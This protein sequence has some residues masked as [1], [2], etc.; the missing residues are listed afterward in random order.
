SMVTAVTIE[1]NALSGLNIFTP[2]SAGESGDVVIRSFNDNL[3]IEDLLI[4]TT[5]RAVDV[6]FILRGEMLSFGDSD[7]SQ[8]GNVRIDSAGNVVFDNVTVQSSSNGE[9]PAGNVF[10]RSP[11]QIAF[12]NSDIISNT[13]STGGAGNIQIES[14]RLVLGEGDLISATTSGAG[15]GGNISINATEAVLLGEGVQ[16]SAPVIS[17]E[18]SGAGRPGNIV[19]NTPNFTLSETAR[20][21]ATSTATAT[22]PNGGGSIDLNANQMALAGTVGIFAETQGQA[23]GGLLTLRPYQADLNSSTTGQPQIP[24]IESDTILSTGASFSLTLAE[25]SLISASTTSS[26]NG[27]GLRLLA[28]E[29]I[30]ISGPGHLAVE[31]SGTGQAGNVTANARFLT[32]SNGVVLSAST[33]GIG[34]AGNINF[35]ISERLTIDNSTVESRTASNSTGQGGN[36][37]VSSS[38]DILLL[39]GGNF[40]LNS[41][42]TGE[43][44]DFTL[45]AD[46]LALD[47]GEIT[48]ITQSSNGGDFTFN[49]D[50]Y[51]LL[52]NGSLIST[53]AG[54][55][56]EGGNGGSIA[57]NAPNGFIIAKPEENSDIR[58]NAF[59][60]DG[61]NVNITALNLLGIAFRPGLSDTPASD[62]TSSSQFGNSGTVTIDELNPETLQPDTE[63][64][65]ETAPATVA[66]G[67]RAQG[68]QTG[69]FVSTGRGGLPASPVSPLSNSPIWQD[70]DSLERFD[71]S[72]SSPNSGLT[73]PDELMLQASAETLI[74]EAQTW[75][76]A[77]D[78]TVILGEESTES[79]SHL[80]QI[81]ACGP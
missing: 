79:F 14:A 68:S 23:P 71:E 58:A 43:G 76:R 15:R 12:D 65:V 62:I 33:T 80:A 44:G 64:P 74:V 13:T 47:Q 50:N 18:T 37:N 51:L 20:I 42:G 70:I 6:P 38:G 49:L 69:S 19:I 75:H 55:A 21:T 60:G 35:D 54:T 48:A 10:I 67:C 73:H 3:L 17:V 29:A 36:I 61:G 46:I 7:F 78:G 72:R 52:R 41:E 57:I 77:A 5:G 16:N 28:P 39:N 59:E 27:G 8:S 34:D 56:G 11:G 53:E 30:S 63:L 66:R 24:V 1:A 32:L 9:T 31:T 45:S 4:T 40:T 22:N 25:N 81:E 26:G 2:S